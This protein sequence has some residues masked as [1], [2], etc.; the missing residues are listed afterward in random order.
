MLTTLKRQEGP[1]L[2]QLFG[3]FLGGVILG[4]LR[5]RINSLVAPLLARF[6]VWQIFGSI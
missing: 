2:S 5:G 6:A 1:N 4:A 3:K